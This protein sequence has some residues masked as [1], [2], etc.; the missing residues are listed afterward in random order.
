MTVLASMLHTVRT[1]RTTWCLVLIVAAG[2]AVRVWH[3]DYD[4]GMGSHPDERSNSY[5]AMRIRVPVSPDHWLDPERSPLNPFLNPDSPEKHNFTYGHFPLY[6]G[7]AVAHALHRAAP[8]L[9]S[10]GIGGR[11]LEAVRNGTRDPRDLLF[12]ARLAIA[13]LDTATIALVFL[14]GRH[15]YGPGTGLVAAGWY[16]LAMQPV[17]DSHFFTF[18]PAA[19]TFLV[20]AGLGSVLMLQDGRRGLGV[21]LAGLGVGL[22][23]SSK[24]SALVSIGMP[25]V[26]GWLAVAVPT[27]AWRSVSWPRRSARAAA[28]V[29][30][31][32]AVGV[33]AFA[34]T[35]P[36]S[37]LDWAQ[38]RFAVID[39][40]GDM[41]SGASDWPFTRQYR[42]TLPYL[43]FL[44]QQLQYGLWYPLGFAACIGS[45]W[46][47]LRAVA[48]RMGRV[49]SWLLRPRPGEW[50]ILA[51]VVPYFLLTGVFLAKFN[52]YMLPLLPFMIVLGAAWAT[53]FLGWWGSSRSGQR[54][55]SVS[56]PD[57]NPHLGA[58]RSNRFGRACIALVTVGSAFWLAANI[59]GIYR[60]SHTWLEASRWI[61]T[62]VEPGSTIMW[63]LWDD[64]LPRE[65]TDSDGNVRNARTEGYR[66]VEFSAFDNDDD[67]KLASLAAGLAAAD[68]VVYS[69]NR[70]YGSVPRLPQRYPMTIRYYEA[71]WSGELGFEEVFRADADPRLFGIRMDDDNADESWSL[72]DHPPVSVF[73]KQRTLTESD[74]HSLLEPH[75]AQARPW[76]LPQPTLVEK[77]VLGV[78]DFGLGLLAGGDKG[79]VPMDVRKPDDRTLGSLAGRLLFGPRTSLA[80]DHQL[81]PDGPLD[82]YRFNELFSLRA[83]L[84]I[85]G[86]W[87]VMLMLGLIAWP[88]LF[89]LFPL[90]PDKGW[91]LARLT[92]LLGAS[93]PVWWVAHV[94]VRAFTVR[95]L[96]MTVAL[97][98]ALAAGS[99][100]QQR[101]ELRATLASRWRLLLTIEV[102]MLLAVLVMSGLRL[103]NPD[104][105]H[106]W[107]GGE[108]FMDIAMV[109]GILASP[110]FPP[111]DPHFAGKYINYY[112]FGQY[113]VAFLAKLTG[114][115]S[116][117]FYNVALV[118]WFALTV[119]LA[120]ASAFYFH[121]AQ[122]GRQ[123]WQIP[124][125]R[126]LWAPFLLV[127]IG[128]LCG[129]L[130]QLDG[131]RGRVLRD[132]GL[133][134]EQPWP[135][136]VVGDVL[137]GAFDDV[138]NGSLVAHDW[139]ASSRTIPAT[140]TE[141]P[142]WSF[143]F[144]DLHAHLMALPLALGVCALVVI[145][146]NFELSR[147][148]AV[149]LL[150][151]AAILWSV[152]VATNL[153]ELPLYGGLILATAILV[154]RRVW[155]SP[156]WQS[157]AAIPLVFGT[158]AYLAGFPFWRTFELTSSVGGLD[159]VRSGDDLA[160]WLKMWGLF[161]VLVLSWQMFQ[162]KAGPGQR[163]LCRMATGRWP[164]AALVGLAAATLLWW[165]LPVLLLTG[166]MLAVALWLVW[167][168]RSAPET[169]D[170][171]VNLLLLAVTGIWAGSQVVYV[172]DFL[173]GS[174]YY[175]MNT[176]FKFFFQAWILVALAGSMAL[177]GLWQR[178]R[179]A[180][181]LRV[182]QTARLAFGVLLAASLVF[183]PLG[184]PSRLMRRF[185]VPPAPFS[186]LNG[187]EFMRFGEYVWPAG[188]GFIELAS[189]MDAI[190]WLNGNIDKAWVILES[191]ETDYYRAGGTRAATFTG[192]SGLMGSHQNEKRHPELV[193]SRSALHH[194]LWTTPDDQALLDMLQTHSIALIYAGQLE[195]A[196]HPDGVARFASMYEK[197]L[198]DLLYASDLTRIYAVPAVY[199]G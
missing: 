87:L 121:H 57:G 153:W 40:Q 156:Q 82:N 170:F 17:K 151:C 150:G 186:T 50:V 199:R 113:L 25:V 117:V 111:I 4:Q 115:W 172:A 136:R 13:L 70:I 124:L 45:G 88:F 12:G 182:M 38:Y 91:M 169:T 171:Q 109:N 128:N 60:S 15:V 158:V 135:A 65:I 134:P 26:A 80:L 188:G 54:M 49:R 100:W 83:G 105:W 194:A 43:Y 8:L 102:G 55:S 152:L 48:S 42:G 141:F 159:L 192:L 157:I 161:V 21:I 162:I 119:Q 7:V 104:L 94:G 16:A 61:Y 195:Q 97:F 11:F 2:L 101:T 51:W 190:H 130:M 132:S 110:S 138:R 35:S 145:G 18:D 189:D 125:R 44:R 34:V 66:Y 143:L 67:T 160:S 146:L 133:L 93:L 177:P 77:G 112:Y 149:A 6:L 24:F 14:L 68:Y 108:K 168:Q 184:T 41:V 32:V 187:L 176:V 53:W 181:G 96:W 139:W 47:I 76:W 99:A 36:F 59:Q 140:I 10:V 122:G 107:E 78:V 179:Q 81:I 123:A 72:Y 164:A 106:P 118:V 85:F 75:L 23:V 73:Q 144:G 56:V 174:D 1:R 29:A 142:Y 69:S 185:D 46:L 63:E 22:S 175:R 71:M 27:M 3:L 167:R 19:T 20:L 98:A 147:R 28:M 64:P 5:Y 90:L 120:W 62:N 155:N 166:A 196:E 148:Q 89:R 37:L 33:I 198:L 30:L 193:A 197:G 52:R 173:D 131:W 86:G 154:C 114:I 165:E 92:G 103:A 137:A 191:S 74:V 180:W 84:A 39:M 163:L 129:A 31:A 95:G 126:A 116:E 183:L 127:G 79:D 9:E 178:L 58:K